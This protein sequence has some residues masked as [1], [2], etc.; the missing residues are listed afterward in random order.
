MNSV[1]L[2]I[3]GT[4]PARPFVR[5]AGGKAKLL[6]EL[7]KRTPEQFGRYHEWFVGGGA[8]F[9]DIEEHRHPQNVTLADANLCLI[10]AY[11]A[12]RDEVDELISLL[13]H[14]EKRHSKELYMAT[15]K[16]LFGFKGVD[17]AAATI[18][19]LKT[20][21][22]GLWRTNKNGGYNVPMDNTER[23]HKRTICD[24]DNLRAASYALQGVNLFVGD[25]ETM[26]NDAKPGDF[27]YLD[28]PYVPVSDSADFTAYTQEGFNL[29]DQQR[30][31]RLIW[32]LKRRGVHV[33]V[34]QADEP[35]TRNLYSPEEGFKVESVM[36]RR[37]ISS[38]ATTRGPVGELLIT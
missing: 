1:T 10:V 31:A 5:W 12:V 26:A 38:D 4:A 11:T 29:A 22:N 21:Y 3:P 25:F 2:P 6:P 14:Y 23:K 17:L 30:L 13:K 37:N 28:P 9:F 16:A 20:N 36:M 24:V 15:R 34:S 32:N 19:L 35:F 18:Y 33:L 27:V 8:M 7:R